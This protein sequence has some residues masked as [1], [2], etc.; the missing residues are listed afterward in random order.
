MISEFFGYLAGILIVL[1]MIPQISKNWKEKSA[2]DISLIRSIVYVLGVSSFVVY[3][4]KI[5]NGPILLMNV[6]GLFLGIWSL[7]LKILYG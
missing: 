2:K 3:G 1:S 7:I 5:N 4:L 6:F